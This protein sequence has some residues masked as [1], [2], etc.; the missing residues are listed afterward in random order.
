[1][2]KNSQKPKQT[3]RAE[4]KRDTN[5]YKSLPYNPALR[6]RARQLRKAGMLHEVLLWQ[7]L[8]NRQFHGLDF[9]RQKI[10]GNYIVDFYCAS[11]SLVIEIDGKSHDH[12]IEYDRERDVFLTNLGL[13]VV[14][15]NAEEVLRDLEGVFRF[16]T[17]ALRAT[18]TRKGNC[19]DK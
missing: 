9:D 7:Q 1:M 2:R 8:R 6:D 16:L 15:I 10:I 18:S 19:D 5:A 17:M 11:A 4:L 12:K 13:E 3:Q 14:H